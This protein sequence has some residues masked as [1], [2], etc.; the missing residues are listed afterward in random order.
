MRRRKE[1]ELR[2]KGWVDAKER[3]LKEADKIR[4]E[5]DKKKGELAEKIQTL[6]DQGLDSG[7]ILS[8]L[9]I[10][11]MFTGHKLPMKSS[12]T[13]LLSNRNLRGS[14]NLNSINTQRNS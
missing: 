9:S 10:E 11:S 8:I 6:Q 5:I 12:S 4:R 13:G 2:L 3:D 1:R 7:S 14:E